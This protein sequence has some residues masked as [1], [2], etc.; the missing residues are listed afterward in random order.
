MINI[1]DLPGLEDSVLSTSIELYLE[2]NKKRIIPIVVIDLTCG[3]FFDIKHFK[4]II[5]T[6]E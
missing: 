6:L 2:E 4:T 3:G 5:P 1:I